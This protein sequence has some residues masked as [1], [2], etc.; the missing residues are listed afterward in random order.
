MEK[1]PTDSVDSK[2]SEMQSA[3]VSSILGFLEKSIEVGKN[4]SANEYMGA[5]KG[6]GKCSQ[7]NIP[8]SEVGENGGTTRNKEVVSYIIILAPNFYYIS[9]QF[10][11]EFFIWNLVFT[12]KTVKTKSLTEWKVTDS[13]FTVD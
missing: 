6:S 5:V 9:T 8:I 10:Q 12:Q 1:N 2:F 7:T 11:S 3:V 4:V 13:L